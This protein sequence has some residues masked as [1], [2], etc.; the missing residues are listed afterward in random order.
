MWAYKKM[1]GKEVYDCDSCKIKID[2]DVN[3][4]REKYS[5]EMDDFEIDTSSPRGATH[6]LKVGCR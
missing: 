4:A 3:G 2:R 6:G 1:R 5:S